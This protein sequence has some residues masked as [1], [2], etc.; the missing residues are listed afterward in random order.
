VLVGALFVRRQR[1]LGDP[2]LYLQFVQG[3]SPPRAALWM[4][5][6]LWRPNGELPGL[7][8]A[9]LQ[10]AAASLIASGSAV[11]VTGLLVLTQ[12]GT[13]AAINETGGEF[14]YALGIVIMATRAAARAGP[15]CVANGACVICDALSGQRGERG[16]HAG[17]DAGAPM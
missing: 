11:S 13:A 8:A 16:R 17:R 5:L 2:L 10:A 14:G 6:P 9:G 12:V 1:R 3:L 4:L 15:T 7:A